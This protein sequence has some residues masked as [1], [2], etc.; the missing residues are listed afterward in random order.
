LQ[1]L[2]VIMTDKFKTLFSILFFTLS[3]TLP[4]LVLIYGFNRWDA[5]TILVGMGAAFGLLFGVG[6]LF[7][8]QV[9]DFTWF[10]ASLPFLFS[11]FFTVLPDLPGSID[12]TAVTT[13][14]ALITYFLTLRK[15]EN[16]PKWIL[17]PLLGAAAYT[18]F[19]GTF[20]GPFDEVFVDILALL[21]AGAGVRTAEKRNAALPP[22]DDQN[23][24]ALQVE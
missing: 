10:T 12:D 20:P 7:L 18:F 8:L 11:G 23:Q 4:V 9:Q 21:V 14:G 17:L 2:K 24:S 5:M 1:A 15:K 6:V 19:G 3:L 22:P 16:A 13:T